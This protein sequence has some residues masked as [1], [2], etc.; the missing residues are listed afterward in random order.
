V[1]LVGK[2]NYDTFIACNPKYEDPYPLSEKY[3]LCSRMT[4][5]GE[6][7]GIY[8]IDIFGNELPV[9]EEPT[10]CFDPMRWRRVHVLV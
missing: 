4:G 8:L 6:Q 3:F 7:M 2:G 10:G 1:D 5:Q 9:H